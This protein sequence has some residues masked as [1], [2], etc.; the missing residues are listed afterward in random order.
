MTVSSENIL[1]IIELTVAPDLNM[2]I[3]V[4]QTPDAP[5]VLL[6]TSSLLSGTPDVRR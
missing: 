5:R 3:I 4:R 1:K 6:I 2:F